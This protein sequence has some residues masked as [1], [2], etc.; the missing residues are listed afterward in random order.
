MH[1]AYSSKSIKIC[2]VNKSGPGTTLYQGN[3]GETLGNRGGVRGGCLLVLRMT[4]F[5]TMTTETSA[6]E[7]WNY[8]PRSKISKNEESRGRFL[9]SFFSFV[10]IQSQI[11]HKGAVLTYDV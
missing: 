10:H 3:G 6:G 1:L 8:N 5:L 2:R 11:P 7:V 4:V 9:F